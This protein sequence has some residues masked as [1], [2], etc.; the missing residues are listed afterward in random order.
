MR[1]KAQGKHKYV[2]GIVTLRSTEKDLAWDWV[3]VK[4][5]HKYADTFFKLDM[6]ALR[7]YYHA[8][9]LG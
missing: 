6:E 1:R 5:L 3:L 7:H 2:K 9:R 4:G 8:T